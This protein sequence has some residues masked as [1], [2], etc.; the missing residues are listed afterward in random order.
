V[1]VIFDLDG[2]LLDSKLL[3]FDS[4]NNALS[5]FDSKYIIS[6][7]EHLLYYDGLPTKE[8]LKL[9]SVKKGLPESL[10]Q[11]IFNYKQQ[12]FIELLKSIPKDN[13]LIKIFEVLKKD[14]VKIAVA[15][16]SIRDTVIQCLISL[17]INDY[18]DYY[19][20]NEDVDNPKPHPEMFWKCMSKLGELPNTTIILEDSKIG[21]QAAIS[22]GA[23]LVPINTTRD[24]NI[25]IIQAS[26]QELTQN[27]KKSIWTDKNL[28]ILIPMAGHGSR[29]TNAGY[30]FP[31]PLID[32]NG[33]PMI[34]LVVRNINIDANYI[35]VVQKSHYDTYNLG[36]MLN[37]ITPNCKIIKVEGVT[38]GAA[39]TTLLAKHLID[40]DSSLLICNSDQY[41][42]WDSNDFMYSVANSDIDGNILVFESHHPKWSYALV[43]QNQLV[44]EVAEKK[45]ISNLATVGIYYW[46]K[47][48]DYVKYAEE[49]I[50]KNIRTNNE[51]YVCPVY[52]LAINDNKKI[53]TTLVK[54]MWGLGTPEDLDNF[55]RI[56]IF[57]L[58]NSTD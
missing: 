52:N 21:R 24:V 29:F 49:M 2:V 23:K 18:I 34:E 37:S 43:D 56:K 12:H 26:L 53:K 39:C 44:L 16:N 58:D 42:D 46:K 17:G 51:F 6:F 14:N 40:N 15:S 1:L 11:I 55:L 33:L 3:H 9:L 28:N 25:S 35:Y 19:V 57:G 8:K 10:H 38:E 13:R 31:K 7:E 4:F 20:S 5:C 32:V 30:T 47:G 54:K 27:K 48:S 22:S 36:L 45:V 50:S 41:V